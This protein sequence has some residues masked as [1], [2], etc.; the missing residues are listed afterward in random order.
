VE[1]AKGAKTMGLVVGWIILLSILAIICSIPI[2]LYLGAK[3]RKAQGQVARTLTCP[4][5]HTQNVVRITAGAKIGQAATMGV[6]AAGKMGKNLRCLACG[7]E[8]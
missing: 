7:Y 3:L 6:L 1:V 8:W 2:R 4:T 5:C